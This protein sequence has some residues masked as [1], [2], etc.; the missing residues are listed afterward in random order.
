MAYFI[1]QFDGSLFMYTIDYVKSVMT[2]PNHK[3][4]KKKLSL[5]LMRFRVDL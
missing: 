4:K 2:S 5:H 3:Y 1:D